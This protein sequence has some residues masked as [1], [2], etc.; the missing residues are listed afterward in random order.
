MSIVLC[1]LIDAIKS[2]YGVVKVTSNGMT[3][4][5]L[6]TKSSS[7]NFKMFPCN[8]ASRQPKYMV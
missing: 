1:Y 7:Q 6:T 2:L 5:T 8:A 4:Q 3:S